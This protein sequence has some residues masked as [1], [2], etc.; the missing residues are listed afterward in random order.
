MVS[1]VRLIGRVTFFFK[2]ITQIFT[3]LT[4]NLVCALPWAQPLLAF[5]EHHQHHY[6]PGGH[7]N[8]M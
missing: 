8:I 2:Q 4:D 1:S 5:L 3:G 7:V 6:G